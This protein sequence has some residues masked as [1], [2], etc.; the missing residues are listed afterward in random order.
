[1][2]GDILQIEKHFHRL[3]LKKSK[4]MTSL[5]SLS[6]EIYFKQPTPK[7][8]SIAQVANH[9][10]RSEKLSLA[11]LTKKMSNPDSI[12][13]FHFKSWG[14]LVALKVSLYSPFKFKAPSAINMWKDQPI[15]NPHVLHEKWDASRVAL[16]HFIRQYQPDF[17]SHLIYKHPVAGRMTMYQT[18]I[19]LNDHMN[20]HLKQMDQIK[21]LI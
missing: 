11:Y 5:S 7:R 8:W 10:Y 1:M 6:T 18:L 21:K 9:L 20:R 15:H 16:I 3:E 4:L 12:P 2:P 13:K 14:T 17:G 19:F